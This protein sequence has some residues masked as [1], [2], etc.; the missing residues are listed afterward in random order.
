MKRRDFLWTLSAA[1]FAKATVAKAANMN[2]ELQATRGGTVLYDSRA[3]ALARVDT[4]AGGALWVLKKDLP[5]INGFE[6]KPQGACRE[7]ICIPIAR[8]MLRG[9][10]FNL[11]AFATRVG[12]KFIVDPSARVWSFGEIPV[13]QGAYVES[14]IA[15]DVEIPDRQGRPVRLSRFRGEKVLLVTWASW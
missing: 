15:P 3:V 11:T 9:D 6:L 8:A 13:V 7:D 12:Q 14:R 10:L 5:R 2:G 4:D 1:T